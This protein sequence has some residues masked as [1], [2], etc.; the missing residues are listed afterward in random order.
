MLIGLVNDADA[1]ALI[2]LSAVDKDSVSRLGSRRVEE[3][4]EEEE[5]GEE[6]EE[7]DDDDDDEEDEDDEDDEAGEEERDFGA[8]DFIFMTHYHFPHY[9]KVYEP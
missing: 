7:E 4:E 1:R 2:T 3:E 8:G 5:G 9:D 6:E